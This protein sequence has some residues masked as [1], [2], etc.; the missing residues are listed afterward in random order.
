[1]TEA[2]RLVADGVGSPDDLEQTMRDGLGMRGRSWVRSK[3]RAHIHPAEFSDYCERYS[4][5]YRRLAVDTC[6]PRVGRARAG[7]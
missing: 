4:G 2:M 6:R 7:L 1:M 3:D 5:F